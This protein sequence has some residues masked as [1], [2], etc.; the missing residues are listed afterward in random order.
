MRACICAKGRLHAR[1]DTCVCMYSY[2]CLFMF[3]KV[4]Y[5]FNI[6]TIKQKY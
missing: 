3:V 2:V 4:L 1:A 5:L 6:C